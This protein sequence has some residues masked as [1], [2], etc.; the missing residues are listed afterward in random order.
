M[1]DWVELDRALSAMAAFEAVEVREDGVWLAGFSAL[2]YELRR[3][4]KSALVHL[5]SSERNLTRR[6]LRVKE[7]SPLRIVL[8]VQRFGRSNAARLE[9]VR[10]DSQRPGARIGREEFRTR[11][12]R[13]LAERFPDATID[14][15]TAAPDLEH[16]FSGVYVRGRMHE[17][18][19]EHAIIA[20]CASESPG[21]LEGVL[22]F[23]LLWLDWTRAHAQR[24]PVEGLRVFV[25]GGASRSVRERALGLASGARVEI[26]EFDEREGH[27]RKMD[28]AAAGNLK[29][30]MIPRADAQLLLDAAHNAVECIRELAP[31]NSE[32]RRSL[33][34]R[35]AAAREVAICYK[36]LAFAH[37]SSDGLTFGL[38]EARDPLTERTRPRLARLLRD[39]NHHRSSLSDET[40]QP[41]YRAA[42]ERWLETLVL[43][44]PSRLDGRL[45]SRFF[46][47]SVPAIAAGDRGVLDILG[48]T[49]QGRVVVIELKASEDIHL[50]VQAV[51]YWLRVR[52]HQ[53]SGDFQEYGYFVGR[54]ISPEPPMV[55][56]VAPSLRF[57]PAIETILKFLSPEI[58]VSRIG[59]CENWRR[60]VKV[61]LRQ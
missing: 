29:S 53:L 5:W 36:G 55:W 15:L 10:T 41:L 12:S 47:S 52:R 38:G 56:L 17:G 50:P 23:G 18:S 33:S 14:S 61:V 60:G 31:Q 44:D 25:P 24:R 21:V 51:D 49:L 20:V 45:D 37:W 42:P 6:I 57:H 54:D 26:F 16:S 30:R 13:F 35:V 1:N 2:N 34:T 19:S 59:V 7:Q 46:Y 4:G 3:T 11:F 28:P 58:A 8:E 9:F 43:E 27:I 32:L 22:T 48:I 40:G 39:L